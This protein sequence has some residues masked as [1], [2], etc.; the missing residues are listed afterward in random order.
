MQVAQLKKLPK[1]IMLLANK[2]TRVRVQDGL[3]KMHVN[4]RRIE[5]LQEFIQKYDKALSHI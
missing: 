5:H 1:K 2:D 4:D 3:I